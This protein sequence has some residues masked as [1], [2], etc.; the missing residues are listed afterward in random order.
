MALLKEYIYMKLIKNERERKRESIF[1]V[2]ESVYLGMLLFCY[3]CIWR[4]TAFI[5]SLIS[6][7]HTTFSCLTSR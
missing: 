5:L 3:T 6:C 2:K 7:L 1:P 4:D